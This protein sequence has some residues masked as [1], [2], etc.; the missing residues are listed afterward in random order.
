MARVWLGKTRDIHRLGFVLAAGIT[1]VMLLLSAFAPGLIER[2]ESPALYLRYK[3]RGE[4]DPGNEIVIVTVDE[5]SLKEVGR[6][7]WSRGIQAQLVEA[8]AADEAKVIG[9]DI[10]YAEKEVSERLRVLKEIHAAAR[11]LGATPPALQGLFDRKMREADIDQQFVNA[12]HQGGNVVLALPLFVPEIQLANPELD[13]TNPAPGYIKR[14]QFMMVKDVSSG[15]A[16]E[17]LY[18]T[19]SAP[20]LKP[21][22][23]EA[24]SLG[25]V[26]TMPDRDGITRYEYLAIRY[27]EKNDYYPSLSLEVARLYLGIPR[28]H[29]SLTLGLGAR[30]GKTLVP[31]DRRARLPI[32]HVGREGRFPYISA[33]DVLRHRVPAGTFKGKAVLVGTTAVGTYDQKAT[34]FS[35]N[36]PGVEKNATVVENIIH[37]R[38]ILQSWW[39]E[40]LDAGLVLLFGLGLGMVLPKVRAL[41]GALLA[42]C[43]FVGYGAVAQY[44]FTAQGLWLDVALPLLT[45]V[46]VFTSITVLRF[47]TEEKQA[48]EVR[49]MFSSY[50]NPRIVEEL[51]KDPAKAKLGGQRKELTM[52]FSDIKG[53]TTFCEQHPPEQV[54][55][56]LNEYLTAMT[57]VVFHWN[58]TLDKFIG[59][60]V[61][62]FWGAPIDQPNH[63]ELALKCALHMRQ[64]LG[65]LQEGWKARGLPVLDSGI[66]I[67]TGEVLVGNIGA[68]GKKMDYTMIGDHVNLAAR[69]EGL[70]RKFSVSVVVTEHTAEQLKGLLDVPRAQDKLGLVGRVELRR[71]ATVKVK[72]KAKPVGIYGLASRSHGEASVITEDAAT[73]EVIEMAEK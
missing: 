48:K 12:L 18:A 59:D 13:K 32:N 33:A 45:L 58:G 2:L 40:P 5:K 46:L 34:P 19:D 3:L 50:V 36:Y 62:A 67:N 72:G 47:M 10:I 31:T 4:R 43:L 26:Y 51:I 11:T 8:I 23:V 25:H 41:P 38:F 71:L 68:E 60:A 7:P 17:P 24:A 64:R 27:G 42:S 29:M 49:A 14:V 73:A 56:L 44:L 57:E 65:E 63:V 16:L 6:W 39:V 69:A 22:A 21:F 70:T 20:P 53:F 30:V 66:G 61:V 1:V 35:A 9:L 37:E 15:E 28:D 55:P 52:L 54:V